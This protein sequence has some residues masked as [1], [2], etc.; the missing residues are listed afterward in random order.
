MTSGNL[1]RTMIA[2]NA[3]LSIETM[4]AVDTRYKTEGL[5]Q[6]IASFLRIEQNAAWSATQALQD[7]LAA[8]TQVAQNSQDLALLQKSSAL[9]RNCESMLVYLT[10]VENAKI[11]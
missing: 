4:Q 7:H 9:F 3:R 1:N 6:L 8:M 10:K 2:Q 5:D 11:A